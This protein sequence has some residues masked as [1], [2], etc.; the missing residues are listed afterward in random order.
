MLLTANVA[1]INRALGYRKLLPLNSYNFF[2][3]CIYAPSECLKLTVP[4]IY[5]SNSKSHHSFVKPAYNICHVPAAKKIS[6][7]FFTTVVTL[8]DKNI[9][10]FA[11]TLTKDLC[12]Y[13]YNTFLC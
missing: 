9:A 8:S 7:L 12:I 5:L 4:A 1:V 3:Y 6:K 2:N 10:I 13:I 11:Q